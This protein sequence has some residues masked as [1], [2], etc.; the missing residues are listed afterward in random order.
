MLFF[1]LPIRSALAARVFINYKLGDEIPSTLD[2]QA[3]WWASSYHN[4]EKSADTYKEIVNNYE[5]GGYITISS[6]II[7]FFSIATLNSIL[8]SKNNLNLSLIFEIIVKKFKRIK[9]KI[10]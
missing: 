10:N 2:E 1:S 9:Y 6:N 7:F 3:N 4:S 5:G 8:N